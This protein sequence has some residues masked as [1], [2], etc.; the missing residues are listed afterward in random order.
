MNYFEHFDLPVTFQVDTAALKRKFLQISKSVHPDFHSLAAA[1]KQ[2]QA[3]ALSTYN[4]EAYQV[5]RGEDKRL[6][7]ILDLFGQKDEEGQ[8]KLDAD[9]LMDMLELN[10]QV[11]EWQMEESPVALQEITNTIHALQENLAQETKIVL[12]KKP[13]ECS[14]TDWQTIKQYYYKRRYLWRI[15]ENLDKRSLEGS[16]D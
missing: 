7:Y 6:L 3:L 11:M 16:T 8:Q 2:E 9:F 12:D 10:E 5:L 1:E 15:L 13:E 14:Q 4:N